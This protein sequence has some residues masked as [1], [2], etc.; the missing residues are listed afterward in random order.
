MSSLLR[1]LRDRK[2]VQWGLAYLAGA[3]GLLEVIDFVADNFAWPGA[4]VRGATV[5]L[6]MGFLV[7]LVLAWYHGEKGQQKVTAVEGALLFVLIAATGAGIVLIVPGSE[8]PPNEPGHV[9]PVA[10]STAKLAVLPFRTL[11]EDPED[12]YFAEGITEDIQAALG[13]AGDLR[14][15]SSTSSMRYRE[16]GD[17][18]L[19]E[20]ASELGVNLVLE[21]TVRR[22]GDRVLVVAHLADASA[23]EEV[24]SDSFDRELTA[25]A[26]FDI[27]RDIATDIARAL[28]SRHHLEL[29]TRPHLTESLE[30]YNHYL[31]GRHFFGRGGADGL[32]RSIKEYQR[33]IALDPAFALAH[34]ALGTSWLSSAHFGNPPHEV[35]PRGLEAAKR[36]LDLDSTVAEAY[37]VL[38]DTR[39]HY[40]WD[41]DGAE[42]AFRRGLT[43]NPSHAEAHWWYAG[44]LAAVGRFDEAFDQL[45]LGRE[46]DPVSPFISAF[47]ARIYY[48]AGRYDEAAAE[49]QR[50]L[51]L[52]PDISYA[53]LALGFANIGLGR[54]EEAVQ[55]MERAAPPDGPGPQYALAT[56]LA[57]AGRPERA[58]ALL[59]SSQASAD[60]GYYPPYHEAFVLAALGER[61]AALARLEAATETRDAELIWVN[62]E[63]AFASL[64][65]EP[66]F[67][68]L[69]RKMGLDPGAEPAWLASADKVDT[70]SPLTSPTLR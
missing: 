27:Q 48:W 34:A 54:L 38:A 37:T 10:A 66:R 50:A 8:K 64:R 58:R 3:W 4:V 9:A 46:V 44:Y 67:R 32:A 55:A 18:T 26:I 56:A 2:L 15:I 17:S 40:E 16:R 19:R 62:V 65:E 20:I 43:L 68:A 39:F 53:H 35:F 14:V 47:G 52:A 59:R 31:R 1:R 49:A 6:A 21:G 25:S 24:W 33:A 63:P 5:T 42:R 36:A 12:A 45:E 29:A 13:S 23:D 69:V 11:S 22:G 57:R 28:H 41:W 60:Q 7:T 51:E 61:E 30:A 70:P